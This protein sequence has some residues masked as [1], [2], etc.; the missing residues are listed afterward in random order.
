MMRPTGA[1]LSDL[2][3]VAL[4]LLLTRTFRRRG[5]SNFRLCLSLVSAFTRTVVGPAILV[6]PRGILE[7]GLG[8]WPND[9]PAGHSRLAAAAELLAK[10]FL[11]DV[12]VVAGV[13]ID[14]EL[15]QALGDDLA[16][17]VGNKDRLRRGRDSAPQRL[18]VVDFL[19]DRQVIET[20]RREWNG[21]RHG[22]TSNPAQYIAGV[23]QFLTP[24]PW[25]QPRLP[26][27]VILSKFAFRERTL[28]IGARTL[29]LDPLLSAFQCRK[30]PVK[31]FNGWSP[32][33]EN[34]APPAYFAL[35]RLSCAFSGGHS[36]RPPRICS[37]RE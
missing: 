22:S 17:P 2:Q 32:T 14:V 7:I 33:I 6:P 34:C 8:E 36:R 12:P 24:S 27:G 4:R 19:V 15:L 26:S 35:A 1:T 5:Q 25:P 37:G 11:D 13:R 31:V 30:H 20:R 21:F 18:Q 3:V 23:G 16:V 10:A 28:P 9:E 29:P